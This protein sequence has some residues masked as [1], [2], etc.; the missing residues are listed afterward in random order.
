MPGGPADCT[1]LGS[2]EGSSQLA[3]GLK[4]RQ[5][6]LLDVVH[7]TTR[8]RWGSFLCS[9]QIPRS[10]CAGGLHLRSSAYGTF[11]CKHC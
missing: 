8:S 2:C 11:S 7:I 6:K 1:A 5:K 4:K 3:D 9:A 10:L